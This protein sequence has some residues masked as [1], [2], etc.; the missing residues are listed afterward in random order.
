MQFLKQIHSCVDAPSG[1]A[2]PRHRTTCFDTENPA[3]PD[4]RNI[5]KP[6]LALFPQGIQNSRQIV[7]TQQDCGGIAL[8]I[9][10]DLNHPIA[11]CSQ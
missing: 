8:G 9:A 2:D 11:C 7:A 5:F 3:K 6:H 4:C 10:A 1:T